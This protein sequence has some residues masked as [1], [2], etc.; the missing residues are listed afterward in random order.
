M[1][2]N[3]DMI[4]DSQV[5]TFNAEIAIMNYQGYIYFVQSVIP[6]PSDGLVVQW[7]VRAHGGRLSDGSRWRW[8]YFEPHRYFQVID[9]NH[10]LIP[11]DLDILETLTPFSSIATVRVRN[12]G[13]RVLIRSIDSAV[14]RLW[15]FGNSS[16]RNIIKMETWINLE[17]WP[18]P[19][20]HRY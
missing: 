1:A 12:P 15:K 19:S 5:H 3:A 18:L 8:N 9:F 14:H 7:C 13:T 6:W 20:K 4:E 16:L 2:T 11:H 10:I 17:T